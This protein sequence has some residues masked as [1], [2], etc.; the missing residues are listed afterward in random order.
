MSEL[1]SFGQGSRNV[2]VLVVLLMIAAGLTL[3]HWHAEWK[4]PGC[5][6]CH[7]RYSPNLH[8]PIAATPAVI[9]VTE[10]DWQSDDPT[11][12]LDTCVLTRSSRAP[13]A[14]TPLAA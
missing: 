4:G 14:F 6:L 8:I 3:P 2:L 9:V 10:R 7:I 13:P 12:E 11:N 5:E 1:C